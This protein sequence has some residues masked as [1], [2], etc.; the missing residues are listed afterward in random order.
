MANPR[1]EIPSDKYGRP[2]N[3]IAPRA[4]A[5]ARTVKAI[6]SS[7]HIELNAE[8]QFI[9]VYAIAKD[10]FLKWA[11]NSV[12]Y[13]TVL[14]F[15]E[16]IPTGQYVDLIVPLQADGTP[17]EGVHLVGRESGSTVVVIEK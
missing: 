16:V 1:Y 13:V 17:Y 8:T 2:L 3:N 6:V 14:N 7:F 10:I 9:R 15:D 4:T 12:D 11:D 5:I